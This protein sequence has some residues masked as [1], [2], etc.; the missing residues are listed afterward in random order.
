MSALKENEMV[1][2]KIRL[3]FAN[4]WEPVL[5][6]KK[7]QNPGKYK[8]MAVVDKDDMQTLQKFKAIVDALTDV[9]IKANG[10]MLPEG[11]KKPLRDGDQKAAQYPELKGKFYFNMSSLYQPTIVDGQKNGF[12]ITIP[13]QV[14]S[15]CYAQL[16][17]NLFGFGVNGGKGTNGG[18]AVGIIGI[19]KLADGE[20]LGGTNTAVATA[21]GFNPDTDQKLPDDPN[22]FLN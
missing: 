9:A 20:A 11:F 14:Y 10:G 22:D 4:I 1:T 13:S 2:G 12:P 16:Y 21:F 17:I 15:G 7:P 6:P 3:N 18:V 5:D 19:S 8:L